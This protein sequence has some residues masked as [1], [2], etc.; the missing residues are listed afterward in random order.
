MSIE[1]EIKSLLGNDLID[2]LVEEYGP[3]FDGEILKIKR[4]ELGVSVEELA[5]AIG[6][7]KKVIEDFERGELFDSELLTRAKKFLFDKIK[8]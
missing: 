3:I 8:E 1:Q 2:K 6:Y 5:N 4:E 7:S